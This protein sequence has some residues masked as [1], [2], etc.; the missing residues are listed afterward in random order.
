MKWFYL[1]IDFFTVIFPVAFSFHPKLQF[2]RNWKAFFI[3]NSIASAV[4]ITWDIIFT[5]LGVWGFNNN[6]ILGLLFFN[7][8]LEEVLFFICVPYACVFTYHCIN[9]YF[10]F[11]WKKMFE[12]YFIILS[13]VLLL[14]AG[15]I[16]FHKIYSSSIFIS[17]GILLL[18]LKYYAKITWLSKFLSVYPLLLIPFFIVNGLLTGSCIAQPVV[19]YNNAE[20]LGIRIFTI[21][22]EDFFYGLELLLLNVFFYELIKRAAFIKVH[23]TDSD[24]G[25]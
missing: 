5:D 9:I 19:W 13:A 2:F 21:P 15:L 17:L 10:N 25:F 16:N 18:I 11:R 24:E 4:F 8:P 22:I 23:R 7:L 1:L 14:A 3:A 12:D 6:Y 20:N